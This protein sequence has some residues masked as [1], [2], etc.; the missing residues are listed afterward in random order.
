[1]T[2]SVATVQVPIGGSNAI[3]TTTPNRNANVR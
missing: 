2:T 3:S 1:M